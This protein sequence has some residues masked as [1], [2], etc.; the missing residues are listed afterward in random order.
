[1]TNTVPLNAQEVIEMF[2]DFQFETIRLEEGI[3]MTR[4]LKEMPTKIEIDAKWYLLPM[5]FFKQWE[6]YSYADIISC[7]GDTD[8]IDRECKREKPSKIIF[9]ALFQDQHKLQ[10]TEQADKFKWLNYQLKD[11]LREGVDFMLVTQDV[12][13]NFADLY[14]SDLDFSSFFRVGVEQE[15][16]EIVCALKLRKIRIIALPNQ[17][18]FK[19]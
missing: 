2:K 14:K 12:I 16:G 3:K 4:M 19:M 10:L 7:K 15:D 13:S 5:K 8:S 17:K 18:V 1:M 11:G 9:A 6:T